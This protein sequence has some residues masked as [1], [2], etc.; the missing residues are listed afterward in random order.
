[1][2]EAMLASIRRGE[3]APPRSGEALF[4]AVAATVFRQQERLW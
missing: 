4:D 2:A 3:A 1:M